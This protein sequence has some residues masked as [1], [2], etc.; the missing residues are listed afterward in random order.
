MRRLLAIEVTGCRLK[1]ESRPCKPWPGIDQDHAVKPEN[2]I[3]RYWV[4]RVSADTEDGRR[5]SVQVMRNVTGA[6]GFDFESPDI[7]LALLF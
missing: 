1:I 7:S 2:H 4:I 6:T 3:A 5:E